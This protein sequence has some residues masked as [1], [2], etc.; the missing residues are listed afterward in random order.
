MRCDTDQTNPAVAASRARY[1]RTN[2]KPHE[3]AALRPA[4]FWATTGDTMPRSRPAPAC[5][6]CRDRRAAHKLLDEQ[7]LAAK[8]RI[9]R[10][11]RE[12][13]EQAKNQTS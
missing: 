10:T 4:R 8:T 6:R 12:M 11:V 7:L 5:P 2:S 9:F 1:P 13:E 3:G